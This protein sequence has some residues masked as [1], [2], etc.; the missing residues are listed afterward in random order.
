MVLGLSSHRDPTPDRQEKLLV[1]PLDKPV[2]PSAAC[3]TTAVAPLSVRAP[4]EIVSVKTPDKLVPNNVLAAL[5]PAGMPLNATACTPLL[6]VMD[7]SSVSKMAL[8][9]LL[10]LMRFPMPADVGK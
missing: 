5:A 10:A 6:L 8:A 2:V 3:P 1:S 9:S 4:Q 7:N